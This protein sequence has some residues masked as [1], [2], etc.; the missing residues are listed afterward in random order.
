M[1]VLWYLGCFIFGTVAAI[2]VGVAAAFGAAHL[3]NSIEATRYRFVTLVAFSCL[4]IAGIYLSVSGHEYRWAMSQRS[5]RDPGAFA[6]PILAFAYILPIWLLIHSW[7][8]SVGLWCFVKWTELRRFTLSDAL[9]GV[10][11][12]CCF[13]A[14]THQLNVSYVSPPI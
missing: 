13:I 11:V 2:G 1:A 14:L 10:A 12:I 5:A 8:L 3:Y 9:G 7:M 4:V 6:V